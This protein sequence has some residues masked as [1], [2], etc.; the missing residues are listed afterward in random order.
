MTT[1]AIR[2]LLWKD[3][4][5]LLPVGAALW[6]AVVAIQLMMLACVW[7]DPA[8]AWFDGR[9]LSWQVLCGVAGPLGFCFA[10]AT[11]G[12]LFAGESEERTDDWLRVL[13]VSRRSLAAAKLT[14]G[15]S[16]L[17][18]FVAASLGSAAVVYG[19]AALRVAPGTTKPAQALGTVG[20]LLLIGAAAFVTGVFL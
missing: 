5:A 16:A 19:L 1:L 12:I 6:L 15:L 13:P 4:R 7:Y 10:A 9:G 14:G 8:V 17:V 18:A 11:A 2:R 20:M 3:A